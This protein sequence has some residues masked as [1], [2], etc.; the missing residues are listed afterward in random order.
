MGPLFVWWWNSLD[1]V[2]NGSGFISIGF[3][4]GAQANLSA[5]AQAHTI[6][7][8]SNTI[9]LDPGLGFGTSVPADVTV[10]RGVNGYSGVV[11][12]TSQGGNSLYTSCGHDPVCLMSNALLSAGANAL[13]DAGACENPA[14]FERGKPPRPIHGGNGGTNAGNGD[15]FAQ[16]PS[17]PG[18][19]CWSDPEAGCTEPKGPF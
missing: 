10:I 16:R 8:A 1:S 13:A 5:F 2:V 19:D 3:S 6:A 14:I 9:L 15:H 11:N 17:G 4:G 7:N 12:L 18:K